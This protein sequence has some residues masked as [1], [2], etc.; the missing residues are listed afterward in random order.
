MIPAPILP[1]DTTTTTTTTTTTD[2]YEDNFGDIPM[3]N[4]GEIDRLVTQHD[5]VAIAEEHHP[6]PKAVAPPNTGCSHLD[7]PEMLS[8]TRYRILSVHED[9]EAYTK[10]LTLSICPPP[11]TTWS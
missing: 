6:R 7:G 1:I 9:V 2:D 10:T 3:I 4:F 11:P 8:F 5:T